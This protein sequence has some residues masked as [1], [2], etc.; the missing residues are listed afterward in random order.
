MTSGQ[1]INISN[2]NQ[3]KLTKDRSGIFNIWTRGIISFAISC[4][5]GC[6]PWLVFNVQD[7]YVR[8]SRQSECPSSYLFGNGNACIGLSDD[9]AVSDDKRI[10]G[11]GQIH[12]WG[13][14]F[15]KYV[16]YI[17]DYFALV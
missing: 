17:F 8:R 10:C 3:K 7:Y 6:L 2:K 4:D 9:F 13:V 16:T 5:S 11:V 15:P 1:R 12:L 14:S